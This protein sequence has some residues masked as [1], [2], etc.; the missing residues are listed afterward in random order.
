MLSPNLPKPLVETD[1]LQQHITHPG[2]KIIDASWYLPE[3][4]RNARQEYRLNHIPGAVFADIDTMSDKN[5][6]VPHTMPHH[7]DF[8]RH[9]ET[10]GISND[11]AV[12][13]YDSGLPTASRVWYMLL[14]VG[15]RNTAVLNGGFQKWISEN[16]IVSNQPAAPAHSTFIP[17][18]RNGY[19]SS[20]EDVIKAGQSNQIQIVDARPYNR[21]TGEVSEPRPGVRAG[22]I[23]ASVSLPFCDIIDL[24]TGLFQPTEIIVQRFEQAG[25]NKTKSLIIYCG[26]GVT[27]CNIALAAQLVNGP[28]TS[29][30]DGSWSEWGASS[31]EIETGPSRGEKALKIP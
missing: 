15:H 31:R 21:F 14:S 24:D 23:P 17:N 30:Y 12:V 5:S 13:I 6:D 19:W 11:D 2:L 25:I 27:A 9:L 10:L 20:M 29:V 3:M 7:T 16:R 18:T 1:W 4:N 26:S 22:H 28:E 8:A